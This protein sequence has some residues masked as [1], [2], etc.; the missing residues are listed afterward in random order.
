MSLR[1]LPCFLLNEIQVFRGYH[2]VTDALPLS[3]DDLETRETTD[4]YLWSLIRRFRQLV[5][6]YDQRDN[7]HMVVDS[8]WQF[9]ARGG[10]VPSG[11]QRRIIVWDVESGGGG[12]GGMQEYRLLDLL[13]TATPTTNTTTIDDT[14]LR[15]AVKR[16]DVTSVWRQRH[17]YHLHQDLAVLCLPD[18]DV[19]M[20]RLLLRI[21][22]STILSS[23]STSSSTSSSSSSTSS[24]LF[25]GRSFLERCVVLGAKRCFHY[26]V[27]L[28]NEHQDIY[29]DLWFFVVGSFK[30]RSDFLLSLL[31]VV[32]SVDVVDRGGQTALHHV[33]TAGS[34]AHLGTLMSAGCNLNPVDL[35][36]CTPLHL[37]VK[38]SLVVS[39]ILLAHGAVVDSFGHVPLQP[40]WE[41]P[42][43]TIV[44]L[45]DGGATLRALDEEFT[46]AWGRRW[47][48]QCVN[49]KGQT[50][51]MVAL[52][53]G[54][55]LTNYTA[56]TIL[57][58]HDLHRQDH[59]GKTLL[60]FAVKYHR[61]T[62]VQW[63]L[64]RCPDLV[65]QHTTDT[66]QTPL[67]VAIVEYASPL[68]VD[69]LLA[70]GARVDAVDNRQRTVLD[71]AYERKDI[72]LSRR[73]VMFSSRLAN[74]AHSTHST[75]STHYT[76]YTTASSLSL[77]SSDNK[78]KALDT[79]CSLTVK[80]Q[81]M[82]SNF[83]IK[84]KG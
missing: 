83:D 67:H 33:A 55:N 12:G 19:T 20:L 45:S 3:R 14:G 79:T 65:H 9:L 57:T 28:R 15:Q 76:H 38:S 35:N 47:D 1:C 66:H 8:L 41:P 49:S 43:H 71:Y 48:W 37:A 51:L 80:K 17:L 16:G 25:G 4:R 52:K 7:Y 26:I 84:S 75:H 81:R 34:V 77:S 22:V 74:S 69:L 46:M 60:H 30:T 18:D 82:G 40:L 10:H 36:N 21:G 44:N 13:T 62:V 39:G 61:D 27:S 53:S 42:L 23:S 56:L 78:R 6:S 31:A 64:R 11:L 63:L 54:S 59:R 73:L 32:E 29:T 70:H 24:C 58:T 72:L 2:T 5:D 50:A 68:V